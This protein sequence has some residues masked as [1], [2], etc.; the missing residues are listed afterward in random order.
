MSGFIVGLDCEHNLPTSVTNFLWQNK[1]KLNDLGAVVPVNSLNGRNQNRSRLTRSS[2]PHPSSSPPPAKRKKTEEK[3]IYTLARFVPVYDLDETDDKPP[4]KRSFDN[5]SDSQQASKSQPYSSRGAPRPQPNISEYRKSEKYVR[6]PSKKR[7]RRDPSESIDMISLQ[8]PD[9]DSDGD[10]QVIEEPK[11]EDVPRTQNGKLTQ[12]MQPI[13]T[14]MKRFA[15]NRGK[16]VSK[17]A[18]CTTAARKMDHIIDNAG[19][20][21]TILGSMESSPDELA[22]EVQDM[23]ERVRSKRPL[24]PSPSLSKR[25]DIR[26]TK[27]STSS[28]TKSQSA[29][30]RIGES[31]LDRAANIIGSRLR[32]VRAVSG[33]LKYEADKASSGDECFLKLRDVSHVLHAT[34]LNGDILKDHAY[35]TVNLK[36]V[37]YITISS[38][39][40]CCVVSINRLADAT[41]MAGAKLMIEFR[42]PE[43]LQHF[44]EWFG[45]KREDNIQPGRIHI[46]EK[47][48]LGKELANLIQI[49]T[50]RPGKDEESKGDDIRLIEHNAADRAR[51]TKPAEQAHLSTSQ[52]KAKDMMRPH[53]S[54]SLETPGVTL[55]P[56]GHRPHAIQRP[57][58]TTRSST[59][60]YRIPSEKSESPE[61]EGWTTQNRGW[62][63]NWRNSLVFPPHGKNRA[64]V[65]KEDIP[66]LDEGQFLND[67]VLIF[68]LR[69]L[70][71]SLEA[72]RPDLAQ[73][74][75]FHNTFF[76]EKLKSSR[77]SQG[78]NYDSVKAWT[79]KVDLFTKDYII[80]P[81][82]EF[83]HW[84]VA[85]IYNAPKLLPSSDKIETSDAHSTDT[86]TI[87]E[88]V[89]NSGTVSSTSPQNV[90]SGEPSDVEAVITAAQ[91]DLTN[92]LSRMSIESLGPL[93]DETK[94]LIATDSEKQK[95]NLP[96]SDSKQD[97]EPVKAQDNSKADVQQI[98]PQSDNL[99]QK[100]AKKRQSVGPRKYN[101]EQPRILT[102]DSLGISHSPA[103]S[104]LRQYLI[105]ELKDKKGIEISTPGALGMTAKDVP[106]QTN[107]CDCGLYLLG[108]IQEFLRSP[109]T[110][111]RSI[112]QRR[113]GIAWNL[114]P[115]Q[116]RTEIRDLI[117]E[118]QKEQQDREDAH[119]EEKRNRSGLTKKKQPVAEQQPL[120]PNTQ[121]AKEQVVNK[122]P[123]KTSEEK[124]I[125]DEDDTA[126]TP[127][128]TSPT[129]KTS[130]VATNPVCDSDVT[131][132]MI[133]SFPQSL[134]ESANM[135]G[136]STVTDG[137]NTRQTGTPKFVSPLPES[138]CDS[139]PTRPTAV[140]NP[141]ASQEQGP[142]S[143]RG[144]RN[145][146]QFNSSVEIIDDPI[147]FTENDR[148]PAI[149]NRPQE[150]APTISPFFA[151]R[152]PA[153]K[154]ASARLR[155]EP[156]QPHVIVD[157][158]D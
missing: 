119:K 65:D 143:P 129:H 71:H 47:E 21:K 59:T 83:S 29:N 22:P 54:V 156:D 20:K 42:Y 113:D 139:S 122:G 147:Q 150:E 152:H 38:D 158:S 93:Y 110:F 18:D 32:I 17:V 87:E 86:I 13:S 9:A 131:R 55:I 80:V 140:D 104:C 133:D 99:Q 157:L 28:H 23:K 43:D 3:S 124:A 51:Q 151:G 107:Y 108:Y 102:L 117:F 33:S 39:P 106:Q 50:D 148:D 127:K 88:D 138:S 144:H 52:L 8:E 5:Y 69:Y 78:I 94:H 120:E 126:I 121:T 85:I 30:E 75:Y 98:S 89:D 48:R 37:R 97:A 70:Q 4:R 84:Y 7:P 137:D 136:S 103:C 105:A 155:E 95:E 142:G 61:P 74:I 77:T 96:S 49:A 111:V 72:K 2:P 118:L 14:I 25:G 112:L 123:S 130:H 35:C 100:K 79:S 56:D 101:P 92:H 15:P 146:E 16:G 125:P 46:L 109:D 141:S 60:T 62:E 153:D 73:R 66:R 63:R 68:Y 90:I 76:Y 53:T 19:R 11:V 40:N 145:H 31:D 149:R 115:S 154:K 128:P 34:N 36:K 58:R 45:M 10:V 116:L 6:A 1:G 82:N 64:T 12:F 134:I 57:A 132:H 44:K 26:Q 41:I 67:N 81:I 24:T 91:H 135:R 27:F 114:N